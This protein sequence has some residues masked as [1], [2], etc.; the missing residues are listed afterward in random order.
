MAHKLANGD[1]RH[2]DHLIRCLRVPCSTGFSNEWSIRGHH[3][4]AGIKFETLKR[5]C[6]EIDNAIA[7]SAA[8]PKGE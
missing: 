7:T 6:D 1:Y 4:W 8:A 2:R 3:Q 5:A